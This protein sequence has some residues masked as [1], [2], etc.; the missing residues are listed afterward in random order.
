VI[1]FLAGVAVGVAGSVV[2]FVAVAELAV[3]RF[4]RQEAERV[5]GR[6]SQAYA[7]TEPRPMAGGSFHD[8]PRLGFGAA[9]DPGT[10]AGEW[11]R[12]ADRGETR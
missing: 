10:P 3:R 4:T 12:R 7:E 1:A 8:M 5:S 2:A 9:L 6:T 11:A